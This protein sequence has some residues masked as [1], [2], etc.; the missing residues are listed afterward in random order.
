MSA[1]ELAEDLAKEVQMWADAKD[2][3]DQEA[4]LKPPVLSA[5][6]LLIVRLS[7][8]LAVLG[9]SQTGNTLALMTVSQVSW[10][11]RTSRS[12]SLTLPV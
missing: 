10:G 11:G 7:I 12:P 1:D 2:K 4:S 8:L 5:G 3:A 6:L 9:K